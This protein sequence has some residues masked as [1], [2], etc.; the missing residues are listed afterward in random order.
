MRR[1]TWA[2]RPNKIS[3]LRAISVSTR[4]YADA[5]SHR[6]FPTV[7]VGADATR[8]DPFNFNHLATGEILR[9]F[10]VPR[11]AALDL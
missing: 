1:I 3:R 9:S 2:A 10:A 8:C 6:I 7:R 5:T 4:C 11:P